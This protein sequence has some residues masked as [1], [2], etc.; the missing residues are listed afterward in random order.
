MFRIVLCTLALTSALQASTIITSLSTFEAQTASNTVATFDDI[1]AGTSPPFTSGGATF[2]TGTDGVVQD[3]LMGFSDSFW[4]NS[5]G[6]PPNFLGT[7]MFWDV[8]FDSNVGAF[9]M[10]M[11]PFGENP[12]NE[13]RFTW[14]LYSGPGL[15][16]SVVDSGS[17]VPNPWPASSPAF[18]GLISQ[19]PFQSVSFEIS[20]ATQNCLGCGGA[21]IIDDFRY[22]ESVPEPALALPVLTCLLVMFRFRKIR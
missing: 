1:A 17:D 2:L 3:S 6:S 21:Y 7:G 14:T 16:G 19:V 9:G 8:S 22:A 12:P 10:L 11:A 20:D 4:F 18:I 5:A 13:S 15:S